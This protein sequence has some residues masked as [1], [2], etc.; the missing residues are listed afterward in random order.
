VE[1]RC[2][3]SGDIP[4][5]ARLK[6][7]VWFPCFISIAIVS[8]QTGALTDT[9][10]NVVPQTGPTNTSRGAPPPPL[11]QTVPTVPIPICRYPNCHHPVTWDVR[12]Y[13]FAEYCGLEHMRFVVAIADPVCASGAE[14]SPAGSTQGRCAASWCF[15][16]PCVW[17][18]SAAH[19]QQV[20]WIPLRDMGSATG[21]A[22]ATTAGAT[23][24]TTTMA[25]AEP[26]APALAAIIFEFAF[27]RS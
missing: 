10:R 4:L 7:Q 13:E 23:P 25:P 5:R 19:K 21:T 6:S 15:P 11:P 14:L 8:S 1:A 12:T 3:T 27:C 26:A 16:L 2:P 9:P 18:I 22:I 24:A 17:E 20:L